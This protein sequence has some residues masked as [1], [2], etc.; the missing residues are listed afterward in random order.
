MNRSILIM[1]VH[2]SNALPEGSTT[3]EPFSPEAIYE[4]RIDTD[5][6]L[7]ADIGYRFDSRRRRTGRRARRS[8]ASTAPPAS[9][10]AEREAKV[11]A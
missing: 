6:D 4:L 11:G 10:I 5:G 9:G 8:A 3:A 2:P 7:V 1:D